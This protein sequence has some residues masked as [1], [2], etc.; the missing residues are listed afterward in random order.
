MSAN[1]N[2][3]YLRFVT[4][5]DQASLP[6]SPLRPLNLNKRMNK[7]EFPDTA[8]TIAAGAEIEI[9]FFDGYVNSTNSEPIA[10][11]IQYNAT[12]TT[13][14]QNRGNS[15]KRTL[16]NKPSLTDGGT[17]YIGGYLRFT[18]SV[19]S[20]AMEH[21]FYEHASITSPSDYANIY[22]VG[23]N[24]I[25][26]ASS[27]L[28]ANSVILNCFPVDLRVKRF[29]NITT[30][31]FHK[32]SHH[33]KIKNTGSSTGTVNIYG[34]WFQESTDTQ[35]GGIPYMQDYKCPQKFAEYVIGNLRNHITTWD[36]TNVAA[37]LSQLD[38]VITAAIQEVTLP[39]NML[40]IST[41]DEESEEVDWS[42]EQIISNN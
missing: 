38:S 39:W 26:Y 30:S 15:F 1:P 6:V 27:N 28:S 14:I 19:G 33:V 42:S 34:A 7:V 41:N 5:P 9:V 29:Q 40:M 31:D 21:R 37:K 13:V 12:P 22:N 32:L 18:G 8:F 3:G 17:A 16:T 2:Y 35:Y 10:L 36:S 11:F 24:S 23:T 25:R 20:W 4:M